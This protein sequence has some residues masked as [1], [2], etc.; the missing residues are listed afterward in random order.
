MASKDSRGE[1]LG[2]LRVWQPDCDIPG[3]AMTRSIGDKAGMKAGIIALPEISVTPRG[4]DD[5]MAIMG[6][7]GLW[8]MVTCSMAL[9]MVYKYYLTNNVDVASHELL[10]LAVSEWS[11]NSL[12]R[13]DI[14][15]IVIFFY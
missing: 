6:T 3:L 7:D 12:N 1:S 14:S 8:D 5:A 15:L 2:I 13:D 9:S 4:E 10:N 11:K